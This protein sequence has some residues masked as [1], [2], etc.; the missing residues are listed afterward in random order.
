MWHTFSRQLDADTSERADLTRIVY[1]FNPSL[2]V[3][4]NVFTWAKT[5]DKTKCGFL[6]AY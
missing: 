6:V 5:Y 3:K 2:A 4:N 1:E